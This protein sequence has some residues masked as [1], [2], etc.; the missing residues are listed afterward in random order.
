MGIHTGTVEERDHN[1]FGTTVNRAAR[2]MAAGH[3]GQI[4]LSNRAAALIEPG[5]EPVLLGSFVLRGLREPEQI[6]WL[7]APG[8]PPVTFP[9][10]RMA[11]SGQ[12]DR[13]PVPTRLRFDGDIGFVGRVEPL[14]GLLDAW[15]A[16]RRGAAPVVIVSGEPG[17][18]KTRLVAEAAGRIHDGGGVVLYGRCNPHGGAAHQPFS[19]AL[20]T[21][22]DAADEPTVQLV[23][24]PSAAGLSLL[25]SRLAHRLPRLGGARNRDPS[26]N[27]NHHLVFGAVC[28]TLAVLA[29]LTAGALLVIDDIQWADASTVALLEHLAL[30]VAPPSVMTVVICRSTDLERGGPAIEALAALRRQGG[31][32]ELR[33]D[34]LTLEEVGD[35]VAAAAGH[36][37]GDL[38]SVVSDLYDRTHGNPFF[39][40]ELIRHLVE[41]GVA[42]YAGG[43][44][45]VG[46]ITDAGV[47][48]GI[49]DL[50]RD[51]LALLPSSTVELLETAAVF[52]QDF[53]VRL[54][55]AARGDGLDVA[56]ALLEP[57]VQSGLVVAAAPGLFSFWHLLVQI[58]IYDDLPVARRI[59]GHVAAARSLEALGA[60]SRHWPEL[61]H[62]WGEAAVAGHLDEAIEA[63]LRAAEQALAATAHDAAVDLYTS[64]RSLLEQRIGPDD[65]EL[66]RVRIAL[67]E[68][69]NMAGRLDE[70][71]AEFVPAA[72]EARTAGRSDLLVRAALG[73][74]GD[75]PSTPPV[76]DQAIV[77]VEQ[78]L[79]RRP[80]PGR[81]RA[82]LL[83]RLAELRHRIDDVATR[84]ARTEEAVAIARSSGDDELLARVML[85]R[86]RS[87][88]G[89]DAMAEMLATSFDVDRI[90]TASGDDALAVRAAQV[91]MN[92]SFALGDLREA[93]H[94]ARIAALLAQR[95][96]QPEFERL[97]LM[98]DAFGAMLEG[99]FDDGEQV[100][101]QLSKVL[102]E[103]RHSQT[104]SM[105]GALLMP[106]LL[107]RGQHDLLY[108]VMEGLQVP[109][110]DAL[111]AWFAAESGRLDR[112]REHLDRAESVA[113]IEADRNWSW[114]QAIVATAN[115]AAR[116]DDTTRLRAVR[117]A[118][119]PWARQHASAGLVT[120]LGSGHHHL[121]VVERALG[122][123]D[124]AVVDL[125]AALEAHRSIGARP[126]VALTQIELARAFDERAGPGDEARAREHRAAA[127]AA[128]DALGLEWVRAGA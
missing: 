42:S 114:W 75:L 18:G 38:R 120:Y 103:G 1:Y 51:R 64:A 10:L 26:L 53:D 97:P 3:G 49:R 17:A 111:M 109:Y 128:A 4:L 47:P 113:Q 98:W 91:R 16:S 40:R 87:L 12:L 107:F 66:T 117:D 80:E 74:G 69:M 23:L 56:L 95:L 116:C 108:A 100:V 105:V 73:I 102:A 72:E 96:R 127:L 83:A 41:T 37:L 85:S 99:R 22:A 35:Y 125:T 43:R 25:D 82:L 60:P 79:A 112:A 122:D 45:R 6:W 9:P 81:D 57:A 77:L 31:A 63:S 89:P 7:P 13:P 44:W 119:A 29:D 88:H 62:H 126:F 30:S 78:A 11:V 84:S 58:T 39:V 55:A 15:D 48:D 118:I 14:Q 52:G 50:V 20:A 32:R 34:G 110:R 115:A 54:V 121:G 70:A 92:A 76:N 124:A 27:A 90:A 101:T 36:E 86:V 5:L 59:D 94:A 19:E 2:I 28:D 106:A 104:T 8:R 46:P 71:E 123:L 24:A 93:Q 65:G 61:A 67:A 68:A 21:F 33:L